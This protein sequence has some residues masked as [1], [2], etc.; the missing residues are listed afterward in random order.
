MRSSFL[1]LTFL[2]LTL[3]SCVSFENK[4]LQNEIWDHK[5]REFISFES[6]ISRLNAADF[7]VI[8]EVHDNLIH[9]IRQ[10]KII[11]EVHKNHRDISVIMEHLDS[12][13]DDVLN[14]F[15]LTK[16]IENLPKQLRWEESGWPDWQIFR[17]IFVT[18]SDL[19]I[20]VRHGLFP[21]NKVMTIY[22]NGLNEV[23]DPAE[24]RRLNLDNFPVSL[25]EQHLDQL[26]ADHCKLMPKEK[27][28]KMVDVQI[29]RDAYMAMQ[30]IN[31]GRKAVL[32]TG[33]GHISHERGVGFFL[34]NAKVLNVAQYEI[35]DGETFDFES[36]KGIDYIW[37]SSPHARPDP[38]EGLRKHFQQK[39]RPASAGAQ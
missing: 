15:V 10:A 18:V 20:P 30:L 33:N 13:Q 24:Y 4:N 16:D 19:G 31:H 26:Y 23:F 2:A 11:G 28:G 35:G 36:V 17:P 32:L 29:A 9:H 1:K 34:Q 25:R 39:N 37:F 8:G 22:Q 38:C 14:S 12:S 27:L 6:F 3:C 21:K 7:L 5:R